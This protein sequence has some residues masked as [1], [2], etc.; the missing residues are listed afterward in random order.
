MCSA[1]RGAGRCG[2]QSRCGDGDRVAPGR[3]QAQ[4][5][6]VHRRGWLAFVVLQ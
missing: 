2:V 3:G 4:V 6:Q 5:N 1:G